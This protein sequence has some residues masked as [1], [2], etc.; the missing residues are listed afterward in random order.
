MRGLRRRMVEA[1]FAD[2]LAA[3]LS[4]PDHSSR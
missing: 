4:A 3:D 2:K 1:P